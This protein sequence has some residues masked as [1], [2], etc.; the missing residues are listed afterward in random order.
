[1]QLDEFTDV[2]GDI[3]MSSIQKAKSL[4]KAPVPEFILESIIEHSD[5]P[6]SAMM[7]SHKIDKEKVLRETKEY[8]STLPDAPDV[9]SSEEGVITV[10]PRLAALLERAKK[11]ANDAGDTYVDTL[12]VFKQ[13]YTE[14]TDN[15]GA[16]LLTSNGMSMEKAVSSFKKI[17]GNKKVKTRKE[18]LDSKVLEKY[19]TNMV[20]AAS[21]G[22]FSPV[23]GR[24]FETRRIIQI[25]CRKSKNNPIIIGEPGVGKTAVVEGLAQRIHRGDVPDF[26]EDSELYELKISALVGG[27]KH[28]G[29]LEERVTELMDVIANLPK[30]IVLFIDE[31]HSIGKSGGDVSLSDL[32]KPALS[33]NKIRIIGATTLDEYRNFIEKDKALERRLQSVF[34]EPPSVRETVGILRGLRDTYEAFHGLHIKDASLITASEL[35]DRYITFRNLP[36]KA[37][38]LIDEAAARVRAENEM[39]PAVMSDLSQKLLMI[40]IELDSLRKESDDDAKQEIDE[41]E[42]ERAN[43]REKLSTLQ[44]KFDTEKGVI[45][46]YRK[47]K[48]AKLKVEAKLADAQAGGSDRDDYFRMKVEDLPKVEEDLRDAQ[49]AFHQLRQTGELMVKEE[50]SPLEIAQ[51]ISDWIGIPAENLS[52]SDREK[53]TTLKG[54][55]EAQVYGQPDAVKG[56]SDAIIRSRAGLSDESRPIGSFLFLGPSGVGKTWLAKCLAKLMFDDYEH[57]IRIDMSEYGEKH[58]VS[59]LVGAPPGYIGFEQGGQLTEAVRRRPYSIVLLDEIEKA[60]PEVFDVLLQVLDDGRLTDGQGRVVNFKNTIIIMTSNI[61]SHLL[62]EALTSTGEVSDSVRENVITLLRAKYR[63]EILNRID[64]IVVFNPLSKDLLGKIAITCLEE[65]RDRLSKKK[66]KIEWTDQLIQYL[67]SQ[68]YDPSQGARGMKAFVKKNVETDIASAIVHNHDVSSF[69]ID[70]VDDK[71]QIQP[72]ENN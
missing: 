16:H 37:I 57:M 18:R 59:R 60:H 4:N 45:D 26:L 38:D 10:H 53:L 50:I 31:I 25:L 51:V 22:E 24:E 17:R 56:V 1:M 71:V 48:A 7:I 61:G 43:A 65:V 13:F 68:Q 69:K 21:L 32:F 58:S 12:T 20:K 5:S 11:S 23:I 34:V 47:A 72:V 27:A 9:H 36:D 3:I 62:L 41:L 64:E 46:R 63:P 2:A 14:G 15:K 49:Q 28:R 8:L 30:N 44:R 54:D 67:N 42:K 70:V 55:I 66:I 35:S 19:C 29:D 52:K 33:R 6:V 40:D 39:T